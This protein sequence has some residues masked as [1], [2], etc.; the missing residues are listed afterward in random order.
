MPVT[1]NERRIRRLFPK[2]RLMV[3]LFLVF[4]GASVLLLTRTGLLAPKAEIRSS[5]ARCLFNDEC[6]SPLVC[7]G[8]MCRLQCR[9]SR[10][11][12]NGWV[13]ITNDLQASGEVR[14][15]CADPRMLA[16]AIGSGDQN[17]NRPGTDYFKFPDGT[18]DE[19]LCRKS[20]QEDPQCL[21]YTYMRPG[22][23]GI[24]A[25]CWLKKG[26]PAPIADSCCI[27]G[28]IRTH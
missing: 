27:S 14:S 8:Q 26:T 21:S 20:C 7:E 3:I 22:V 19:R 5:P 17:T 18:L 9:T 28:V 25:Y 15:I 6:E 13:C 23:Q 16:Q 2:V 4:T 11:C 1:T 24:T 12:T 10:D